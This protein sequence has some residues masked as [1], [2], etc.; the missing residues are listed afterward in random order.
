MLERV[1]TPPGHQEAEEEVLQADTTLNATV[2]ENKYQNLNESLLAGKEE[3]ERDGTCQFCGVQNLTWVE[4]DAA[5]ER[6]YWEA[7]PM[8]M[9]CGLCGQVVEVC[10]LFEHQLCGDCEVANTHQ[11]CPRCHEAIPTQEFAAHQRE[12]KCVAQK[13]GGCVC[14]LCQV[15]IGPDDRGV[16]GGD[17]EWRAHIL[18]NNGCLK[19]TRGRGR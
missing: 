3:V 2:S 15:V 18:Q 19:N 5:L 16:Y 17:D 6:H 14:P 13:H 11:E 12:R 8:L 10:A 9:L 1:E 4:D 7:C